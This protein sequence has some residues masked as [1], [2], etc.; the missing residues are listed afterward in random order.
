MQ[1]DLSALSSKKKKKK[2]HRIDFSLRIIQTSWVDVIQVPPA[3]ECR[4]TI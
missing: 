3:D 2:I 4:K 1:F